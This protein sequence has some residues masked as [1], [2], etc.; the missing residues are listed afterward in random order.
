[1]VTRIAFIGSGGIAE[2]QHFDTLEEIDSAKVVGICDIDETAANEAAERFDAKVF[3]DHE[4]LLDELT[5]DAV[6]I[7]LPPFAHENQEIM[8]AERGINLFVEKPIA[9]TNEK[10]RTIRE[11][12]EANDVVSQVGY[13]WRYAPAVDRAR[14]LLEGRTI[15]YIDGRFWGGVPGGED[16]WWRHQARSGGQ[17]VEQATHNFDM[18]RF[19]A[20]DVKRLY[21]A[22]ADRV[23]D[24]VDFS[25]VTST[26][27]THESGAVSHVSTSCIAEDGDSR[28]EVIA[29]GATLTISQNEIHGSID[30]D[31][32][33]EEFEANPYVTEV[34]SFLE[35]VETNDDSKIRAPYSDA[36]KTLALTLAVTESIESGEPITL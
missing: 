34:K 4:T 3:T 31:E 12:I 33:H 6:F 28:L 14:E 30:G 18:V 9:L 8:A 21:A 2:W 23:S 17:V 16:H 13:N 10:A 35:A 7:C 27:M 19:L 20:G 29:D 36:T 11:A 22:G 32:I 25:D 1:M 24:L 26:T 5:L 15:E